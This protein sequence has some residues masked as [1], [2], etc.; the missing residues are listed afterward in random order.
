MNEQIKKH[1]SL[2]GLKVEDKV[3]NIKGIVTSISFDLYG[4][5][6][7]TISPIV[8]NNENKT[9]YWYDISRLKILNKKPVM[10]RPNFEHGNQAEGKHGCCDK[11]TI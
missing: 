4:C 9:I 10:K 7:A 8:E 6:Q 2:L 5:I 1:I 3:T 11:P